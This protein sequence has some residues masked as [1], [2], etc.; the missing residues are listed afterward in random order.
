MVRAMRLVVFPGQGSQAPGMGRDFFENIP[1]AKQ[2]FQEVSEA[3]H[4]DV[5]ALCLNSDAETLRRTENAQIALFTCGVAAY[6]ALAERTKVD[7]AFMAGHSVGEYAALVAAGWL[8]LADGARLVRRRGDLMANAGSQRPGTMAAV[9]GMERDALEDLCRA[10]SDE[11][12]TVVIANDNCPGQ[13]VVSGDVDAVHALS[14][15]APGMGAKR[16]LPLNVSGAFHSP[17]MEESAAQLAEPLQQASWR[18]GDVKVI[19]NVTARPETDWANLLVEQLRRPV[20]WCESIHFALGQGVTTQIECGNGEVLG[21]LLRRI[22]PN[23]QSLRVLDTA[24][25]DETVRALEAENE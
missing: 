21:G 10:H 2:V 24:T 18:I 1:V 23:R 16:V 17:L 9:L 5:A 11:R 19:S 6:R 3:L 12:Q 14:A 8:D 4:F 7:A 15:D 20:R 13:L 22:E 25:L